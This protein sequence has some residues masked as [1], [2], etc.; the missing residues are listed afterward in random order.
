M[1]LTAYFWST[2]GILRKARKIR[3]GSTKRLKRLL[4]ICTPYFTHTFYSGVD[5]ALVHQFSDRVYIP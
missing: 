1:G 2:S 3:S 4:V 5:I